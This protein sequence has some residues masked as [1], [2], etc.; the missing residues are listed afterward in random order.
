VPTQDG[1]ATGAWEFYV[2]AH[3]HWD[4]EWYRPFEHFQLALGRVVDG[5]IDVLERDPTFTSF[6]LD[7]QAIV[8]EDYLE[9]RPQNESRLR[10]LVAAGRIELGPSYMLPDEF[11]VCGEALVRNLLIGRAVCRRFGAEPTPTGYM[12][13]SFGHPF[14]LPQILAGFGIRSFVFSRGMGDELDEVGVVFRWRGP[15]GSEVLAFQQLDHYGNFAFVSGVEDGEGRVRGI[16]DRFG[17]WLDRAGIRQVLL[18]NGTDHV[19]VAPELPRLCQELQDRLAPSTFQIAKYAD[20]VDAVGEIEAPAWSGELLGSRIQNVLRGVNS[21][22]LYIKQANEAAERRMVEV[23]TLGALRTLDDGTAFPRH[24]LELAWRQLLRCQPHDTIC[25]CS[26]DEVHRDAIARYQ[27]LHRTLGVLQDRA[28]A[29]IAV[30]GAPEGSV[31]VANLLPFKRRGLVEFPDDRQAIVELDG[32]SARVIEP[33]PQSPD[34]PAE[35][36]AIESDRFRVEATAAGAL[37]LIDKTSGRRFEGLHTLEDEPDMGDL[38]NFCPVGGARIWRSAEVATRVVRAGPALWELEVCVEATLPAGLGDD[39]RPLA[40]LAPLAVRTVVRLVQGSGRVEFRTTIENAARDHRLRVGFPVGPADGPVRAETAFAVARRPARPPSPR[41]DWTE[42]PDATQH[43][44]GAVAFG[45]AALLTKGLP[46]YEAREPDGQGELWLTLLRSVGVISQPEGALVTRPHTAGPQV[47]TPE[48]QCLGRHQAE[49]AFLPE[50][51][52]LDDAALLREA[53][54][55]RYGFL[56]TEPIELEPP[57]ELAGDVVFSCLKGAEDGDGLILRC[58]NPS[59][60]P[61]RAQARGPIEVWR[62][63][64][65]ETGEVSLPGGEFELGPGQIGTLRLR[66]AAA[67]GG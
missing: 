23:E 8:L 45:S 56:V 65:D 3:T 11:L 16:L 54:D 33:S 40:E 44:L 6:T 13:D 30:R 14:Q 58:F 59:P 21:A 34:G 66:F 18:C 37:L 41:A 7:G 5:V 52:A 28:V 61:A 20:Y 15:D 31:G 63:R 35:G 32:L 10:A 1:S 53:Q 50:G 17:P 36:A 55:Y 2:V 27:S 9:V 4:R 38:Y 57:L 60:E 67:A 42:P 25:G 51:N 47:A 24:D 39:R 12:P 19:P 49:Y 64:L 62:T 48:G 43:T 29:G 46:E 22:R 26:C